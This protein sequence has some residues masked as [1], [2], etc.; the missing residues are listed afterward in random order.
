MINIYKNFFIHYSSLLI[1]AGFALKGNIDA[2]GLILVSVAMHECGHLIMLYI[3][4]GTA[5]RLIL[6]AFG[7]AINTDSGNLS[8]RK[9]LLTVLG[10]PA[11][12]LILA[13]LFY[14]VFPPL[15]MPNL[16]VGL[17]NLLP[18]LPLDGGRILSTVLVRIAGRK[19]AKII[20]RWAGLC[21]GIFAS[22]AGIIV[23]FTSGYN[24]SLLL[25][26]IFIICDCFSSIFGEPAMFVREKPVLGEI[27]IIPQSYGLRKAADTL[28]SDSIGAVVDNNGRVLRL[29]TSKGI[30]WE[31]AEKTDKF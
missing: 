21:V 28:P 16:C 14:F 10:G 20:M 4:G 3:C 31:L 7:I 15:S 1:C 29:V 11:F 22:T 23:L 9:L 17:I 25:M 5:D 6:H 13:G 8:H 12:S 19:S 27:Y 2:L 18:V 30:Y 26:G 24:F